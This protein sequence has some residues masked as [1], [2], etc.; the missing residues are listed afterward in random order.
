MPDQHSPPPGSAGAEA[1]S[2]LVHQVIGPLPRDRVRMVLDYHGLD[3]RLTDN[4]AAVAARNKVT[5][6][7]VLAHVRRVRAAAAG[8]TLPADLRREA[9][10]PSLLGEDHTARK[11][12]AA[13]L[14][15]PAPAPP[16]STVT[17]A[18]VSDSDARAAAVTAGRVL[19]AAGPLPADVLVAAVARSRRFRRDP[20]DPDALTAAL[21][22]LR[23]ANSDP[24][25]TWRA[26]AAVRAPARYRTIA[27]AAAGRD[28]TR[29]HMIDILT[30]AGYSAASA[31]GRMSSSHPLFTRTG[32]DQYRLVGPVTGATGQDTTQRVRQENPS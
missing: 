27:A 30:A 4:L 19:A 31:G 10:R 8:L 17:R 29:Q 15:L 5:P 14:H 25:G 13:T 20:P 32:P 23:L 9:T 12:I 18:L 22:A 28:L 6:P 11:R 21:T 7:T 16:S 1:V 2:V 26:T 3:G 24:N